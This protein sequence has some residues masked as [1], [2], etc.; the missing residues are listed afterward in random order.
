MCQSSSDSVR[1]RSDFWAEAPVA[2][3]VL[4]ATVLR[5][6]HTQARPPPSRTRH[7][8]GKRISSALCRA[9]NGP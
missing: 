7:A 9:R 6:R 2:S 5:L 3:V 1:H 4:P 8:G